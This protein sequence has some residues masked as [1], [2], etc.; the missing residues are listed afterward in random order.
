MSSLIT[1][2]NQLARAAERRQREIERQRDRER[3][4]C[5]RIRKE[6]ERIKREQA[7]QEKSEIEAAQA[8]DDIAF[9][10]S[11]IAL[12]HEM[13][14]DAKTDLQEVREH[15]DRAREL[16][17]HGAVVKQP[18]IDKLIKQRD[19][20]TRRVISVSNQIHTLETKLGKAYYKA[21]Q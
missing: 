18:E 5:E 2:C 11:Q 15:L 14:N 17:E 12:L 8:V 20:L 16:N 9:Y 21:N 3:R 6:A 10:T 19:K 13:C 4:E 7:K 1:L